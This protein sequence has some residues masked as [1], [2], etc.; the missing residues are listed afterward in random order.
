MTCWLKSMVSLSGKPGKKNSRALLG[1]FL[2]TFWDNEFLWFGWPTVE[3]EEKRGED[4]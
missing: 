3:N 2:L 4:D 1:S